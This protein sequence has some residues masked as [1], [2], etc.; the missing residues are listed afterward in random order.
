MSIVQKIIDAIENR[1]DRQ[2]KSQPGSVG[3]FWRSGGNDLLYLNLPVTTG[4]LVIDAGAYKGEWSSKM[5][6]RYGCQA[7][8]FEPVPEFFQ[9]LQSYFRG[10]TL[11]RVFNAA[12]GGKDGQALFSLL[13]NSTSSYKS[14]NELEVFTSDVVDIIRIV[15]E[16]AHDKQI[17]CMKLNIEGGEYE[18]LE[19]LIES[20]LL[21]VFDS[22][23]IQFHRWPEGYEV[24]Y[25]NIV[26]KL[27]DTHLIKWGYDF[28][29][30]L[31]VKKS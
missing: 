31:W 30:E 21:E 11:V 22:L 23:L 14:S 19:R 15:K 7:I 1:R 10:N 16:H 26:N 29:W 13:D 6:A 4:S 2:R 24:R 12:I 17:S 8:L 18:V 20:N 9:L 28:M 3:E 25:S 27:Q 5:I